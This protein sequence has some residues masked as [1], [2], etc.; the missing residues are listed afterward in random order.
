MREGLHNWT[1]VI[2]TLLILTPFLYGLALPSANVKNSINKLL[3]EKAANL[4]PIWALILF[5]LFMATG[6]ILIV[7][8]SYIRLRGWSLVAIVLAT[9]AF[10]LLSKRILDK[11]G[12]FE[13]KFLENLN[14]KERMR[15]KKSR[16]T[17][18]PEMRNMV[19]EASSPY[20]GKCLKDLNLRKEGLLVVSVLRG[21]ELITNPEPGF[22]FAEGDSIWLAQGKKS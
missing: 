18:A 12:L 19:L 11:Y 5:R 14:E 15:R 13:R 22:V 17:I 6:F 10:I 4:F 3:D 20:I 1:M 8:E 21:E 2:L 7:V 16:E 9:A